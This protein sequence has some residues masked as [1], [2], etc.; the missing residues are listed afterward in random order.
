MA[1]FGARLKNRATGSV[2][3]DDLYANMAMRSKAT[4]TTTGTTEWTYYGANMPVIAIACASPTFVNYVRRDDAANA[5]IFNLRTNT[6]GGSASITCYEFGDPPALGPGWGTRIKRGGVVKYDSRHRYARIV[7]TLRGD[8]DATASTGPGVSLPAGKAYAVVM[9][10]MTGRQTRTI[11]QQGGTQQGYTDGM[12]SWAFGVSISGGAV[13][14]Q[15][16]QT[17]YNSTFIPVPP[18]PPP[19]AAYD[20]RMTQYSWAILDVTNY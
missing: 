1:R 2:Q 10:N 9:G 14:S 6:A 3:I 18:G 12:A 15:S 4:Q 11:I 17:Y 8:L 5:W 7:T 13:S 16:I 19:P 20:R